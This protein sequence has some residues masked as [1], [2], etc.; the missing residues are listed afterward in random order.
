VFEL[1]SFLDLSDENPE[2][3]DLA[4]FGIV[5]LVAAVGTFQGCEGSASAY[6]INVD[7]PCQIAHKAVAFGTFPVFVSSDCVEWCGSTAYARQ[8]SLVEMVIHGLGGAIVRPSR[9][10]ANRVVDLCKLL[11]R[12]G[13]TREPGV[14]R[15]A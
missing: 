9:V 15:W 3:P 7:A 6:R 13:E 8:K 4:T 14:H 12:V 2:I 11:L 1:C 10:N 5:Y